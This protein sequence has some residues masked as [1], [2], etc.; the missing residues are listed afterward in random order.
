MQDKQDWGAILDKPLINFP[1]FLGTCAYAEDS[2]Y[3]YNG[4]VVN[5]TG[6]VPPRRFIG[7]KDSVNQTRALYVV[8]QYGIKTDRNMVAKMDNPNYTLKPSNCFNWL[9]WA[10]DIVWDDAQMK[11]NLF[12]TRMTPQ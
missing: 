9:C 2:I 4:E 7:N 12:L 8:S 6:W 11:Q 3:F 10:W 1:S 5:T